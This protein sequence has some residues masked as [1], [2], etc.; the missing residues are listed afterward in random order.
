MGEEK[1]QRGLDITLL[2]LGLL[3]LAMGWTDL[4]EDDFGVALGFGVGLS[5]LGA[6]IWRRIMRRKGRFAPAGW[7]CIALFAAALFFLMMTLAGLVSG[8]ETGTIIGLV[9]GGAL[10]A[11][12][13][14]RRREELRRAKAAEAERQ[15]Q[16]Q[17]Q[18]MAVNA[19]PSRQRQA[20]QAPKQA[21]LT[22][23]PHCGAP[24]KEKVCPYCG[25]EK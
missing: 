12:Y 22:I 19:E 24:A 18:N 20:P 2:V 6:Y 1:R 3:F 10:A 5:L 17:V 16:T 23:C 13:V 9:F 8:D 21:A 7:G 11:L 4:A 14:L 15:N 25:M